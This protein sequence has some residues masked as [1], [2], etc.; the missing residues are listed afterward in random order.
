[1]SFSI[2]QY[3]F[4]S[5]LESAI[6][7]NHRDF[8]NWPLVYFLEEEKSKEAYVGETTDVLTRL[9]A[10]S[11]SEKKQNLSCVNLI[12]SEVFNK[13]ATLDVESNLIRYIAAD[14]KYSLQNGNLGISN[15]Q[16]YQQKEVY[17]EL[18]KDIWDKLKSMGIARCSLDEIDNSDLFKY[19]P[20]KS[21]SKEQINGLKT[22]LI[23]LLD[24]QAKV[25]LIQ[26][27][28][29]TGKSIL[30]IFLFKLLKTDLKD[31][32]Y[33][34]FDEQD[35]E[36][37]KLLESVKAKYG[38]LNM[39][40][41]IP[42]AS[43]R[44]TISNV[45][46][47]IKGLSHKMVIGPS[48]IT[49]QKYDLLIV[50][51]GHR[52]RRRVNLGSYFGTFDKN[53]ELLGLDKMTTSEL[54]W[55]QLQSEK[56]IIFYDQFQSIKPS[57]ATPESFYALKHLPSTRNEKLITQF[58]VKGGNQYV[59]LVHQLFDK[60][61]LGDQNR[62][63][64][65][66]YDLK[67][68]DDLNEMVK[69]IHLKEKQKRLSRM[70]AG[71]AWEWI[72]KNDRSKFDIVID[73]TALQWNS[74]VTDWVNSPNAI[75]EVGCIHTTQGYD[76]NYTGVII[77]PELDYDFETNQLVVYK[78]H[79]KD[80]NGKNS[81]SN[82]EDLLD[83]VLNIYKTILLRGI[84]G[85]YIYVCNPN[86]RKYFAQVV[87]AFKNSEDEVKTY[88]IVDTPNEFTVPYYDLE[89]AA[90]QFSDLQSVEDVKYIELKNIT[91]HAEYFVCRVVG[92]SMN[93]V[94][95]NGSL[96]LFKKYHGG[97]RNGLITLIEGN[98]VFD[99]ETGANYTIK[100]YSSKK[101]TDEE[102][103]HHKEITLKPLSI[104]PFEPIVLRD[105]ET[106]NFRVMGIF[107][108]KL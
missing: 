88:T 96:C 21:L 62:R 60:A 37:F 90:G 41:V 103:W 63:N 67:L 102:G 74:T 72:S 66:F 36:L 61:E 8:L 68:F 57:D 26:G 89:I 73:G 30:A 10:H 38:D 32:N 2:Q 58:R 47:N 64:L 27:G 83:Y 34:D 20:Y 28:A 82:P 106:M 54:D 65:G 44:K 94:I 101:V 35:E 4:D 1:M 99:S 25:S 78:E 80:K 17:W 48:E 53:S 51:E 92:E 43:F 52:L 69:Q 40:L 93:K 46:K 16:Y 9:K 91:G 13:S 45:F 81:I 77:G 87:P 71:F 55:V 104:Q 76:L 33:S 50:D 98:D 84:E 75:N 105:E 19:S 56:S 5:T 29:G 6:I 15:H 42:M 70:V 22:I 24:D 97:T 59:K 86:L 107:R 18:F 100:E 95:P 23:C 12:L 7:E 3:P 85:T 39:A 31:F 79:Y 11:K 49:R 108:K 14:G